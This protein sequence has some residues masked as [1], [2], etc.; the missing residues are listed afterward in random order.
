MGK[1]QVEQSDS[2]MG[3][4]A[5]QL[6][7]LPA[8]RT[9]RSAAACESRPTVLPSARRP[10]L[11]PAP[12][13]PAARAL[14]C[15][16]LR[17]ARRPA[18][19]LASCT[20]LPCSPARRALLPCPAHRALLQPARRA[21]LPCVSRPAAARASCPIAARALRSAA[22]RVAPCSPA[23]HAPCCPVHRTPFPAVRGA[24]YLAQPRRP[25]RPSHAA[26]PNPSRAALP[27]SPAPPS[28]PAATT[29]AGGGAAESVGSAAGAGG[30]TGSAGGAAG[31]GA[32]RGG[33]RRSLPLPDDPTPQQLREWVLQRA[34]PGGEGFGFLRT[35]QR[36][37]QSQQETFS[38]Q[39]LFELVPQRC[40]TGSVEAAAL[41]A[42]E[43]AA[44]LGASESTAA[45]GVS[46][47]AATLGASESAAAPDAC[48]SAAALGA[49]ASPATGP[50][51]AEALHT[52]TLDSGASR[53]FFRDCTAL[54]PL[55][56]LVPVSLADPTGG[57]VV[58]RA[59][60]VLPYP[61]VPS[62][63]LSG[64]HLPTFSTNL[65]S[66]AA[67]QDVWVDTFIPGGQRV[68]IC[69]CSRTGRHLGTFTRWP[70]SSLYTLTTASTQ[71][72]PGQATPPSPSRPPAT[73]SAAAAGG[74]AAGSARGAAALLLLLLLLLVL[75]PLL[76]EV[77]LGV[78][79]VLLVLELRE[80]VIQRG[81][82]GGGGFG[83]MWPQRP[84]DYASQRCAPGRVEAAALGSSEFDVAPGVVE[85]AAALGARE[86]ADA[87]G[88]S[89]STA[90]APVPVS[91]ADPTGGPIVARASTVLLCPAVP[92]GSLSGLHLPAFSTSLLS[93][94]VLH[95]EWVD[96][97]IPGG[98]RVEICKCSWTVHHLATFTRQPGSG[99][100][101]LTTASAQMTELGQVTPRCRVSAACTPVSL[102]LAFPGPCPPS[103]ACRQRA[104]PHSSEFAP[105][106]AP[107]QTLHMDVWGPALV[108]G[109]DQERY[110]LLFVDDYPHYTTV[111]PLRR[112]A[113]VSGVLIPWIR[114]S[115]RQ[116]CERFRRDFPVLRLHSDKGGEFSSDLLAEFYRDE[117]IR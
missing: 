89:A 12:S 72:C 110:F 88:A 30:A 66:N 91:L 61:A 109:T 33:Q 99:L 17:P 97:F 71:R 56:A 94:A 108:D 39:V 81:S 49:R 8:P 102:S 82:P 34:R 53:C 57:P 85:S 93:N 63:S 115:R 22:P 86:F 21:L 58:A 104:A 67:I 95:D 54:T 100:Y 11:Q 44:A 1:R 64:L 38:P 111:F 27:R 47:S 117:G 19:Q 24:P 90:T 45:L 29:A 13:C 74:G 18:L 41:G 46:E 5:L 4:A 77:W 101:T 32:A 68:A 78:L 51:S 70:G 25:A 7:A 55:A 23:Q 20:S 48:E 36:Q 106:T 80:W 96:T 52:F 43:S 31:A 113:D 69:T 9:L 37:Q 87:L 107:L 35:A 105:T 92:S 28:R 62:G 59:S 6:L 73:T 42:S 98:Q 112:K 14:R 15:P 76:V 114:A 84:R 79:E 116:L 40:V 26:L 103:S 50:S 83:F 60:T 75:L 10:A 65:V 2:D 3:R 16:A